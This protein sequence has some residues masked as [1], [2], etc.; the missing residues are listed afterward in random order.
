MLKLQLLIYRNEMWYDS[1]LLPFVLNM[2]HF[3]M[4]F[5]D[6]DMIFGYEFGQE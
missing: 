3:L 2:E 6:N 1:Y 5:W 4:Y